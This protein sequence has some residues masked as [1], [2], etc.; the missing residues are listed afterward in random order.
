MSTRSTDLALWLRMALLSALPIAVA[1]F[2]VSI[3]IARQV[4]SATEWTLVA[5]S[6]GAPLGSLRYREKLQVPALSKASFLSWAL[7]ATWGA[8]FL[9]LALHVGEPHAAEEWPLAL[10]FSAMLGLAAVMSL[11]CFIPLRWLMGTGHSGHAP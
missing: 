7:S 1:V 2:I 10:K 5:A 3:V 8:V 6:L 4:S 11:M 9:T